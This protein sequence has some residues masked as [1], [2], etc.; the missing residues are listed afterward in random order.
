M[1]WLMVF[2][3]NKVLCSKLSPTPPPSS[4][5]RPSPA[6]ADSQYLAR[7]FV[8][9]TDS[10]AREG[11]HSDIGE[12]ETVDARYCSWNSSGSAFARVLRRASDGARVMRPEDSCKMKR[13]E[14]VN[15]G[16][17]RGSMRAKGARAYCEA[18]LR[19]GDDIATPLGQS[20][21]ET[22][23]PCALGIEPVLEVVELRRPQSQ[24]RASL[25]RAATLSRS[26]LP[27]PRKSPTPRRRV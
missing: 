10:R 19:A 22:E 14:D 6:E 12:E 16:R 21:L 8:Q 27:P 1:S 25:C 7:A 17:A 11:Q 2:V 13:R 26:P 24:P 4:P 9:F 15:T 3:H 23:L 18:L 20:I 5:R